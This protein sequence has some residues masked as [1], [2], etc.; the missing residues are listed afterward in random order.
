M[1]LVQWLTPPL[2]IS[3]RNFNRTARQI[4]FSRFLVVALVCS[5]TQVWGKGGIFPLNDVVPIDETAR[6]DR[7]P[8]MIVNPCHDKGDLFVHYSRTTPSEDHRD[9]RSRRL[10]LQAVIDD[11]KKDRNHGQQAI[12]ALRTTRGRLLVVDETSETVLCDSNHRHWWRWN[13]NAEIC[14]SETSKIANLINDVCT[15]H[16]DTQPSIIILPLRS[17]THIQYPNHATQI[18]QQTDRP[19][20]EFLNA[21]RDIPSP[22]AIA[23]FNVATTRNNAE[24]DPSVLALFLSKVWTYQN[25]GMVFSELHEE[26]AHQFAT[27]LGIRLGIR[28]PDVP[29]YFAKKAQKVNNQLPRRH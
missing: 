6:V 8:F 20:I 9:M 23:H 10:D 19:T 28:L 3:A 29:V 27:Q 17:V 26:G 12:S 24:F 2:S 13:P 7:F 22:L 21:M 14:K 5:I 4:M 1:S 15:Q 25:T 16:L 18:V 11:L